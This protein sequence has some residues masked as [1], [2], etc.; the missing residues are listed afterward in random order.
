[1]EFKISGRHLDITPAIHEYAHKKTERLHRYYDRIQEISVV[2]DQHD[3]EFE[4]EVIVDV[5][6]HDP[7]VAKRANIDLYAG[8]DVT[9]DRIE[10]QL[11]DH[12]EKH[13]NRKH[14]KA[15]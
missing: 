7:F 1:M 3:R 13:R 10:R 15:N 14:P 5:E 6:H 11:H 9:M 4:V 8:I 2:I 12:K